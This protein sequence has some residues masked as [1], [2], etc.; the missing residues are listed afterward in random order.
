MINKSCV[1]AV[2]G[3]AFIV[4]KHEFS[5]PFRK[6]IAAKITPMIEFPDAFPFVNFTCSENAEAVNR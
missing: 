6:I 3:H 1:V 2:Q 5:Q 4:S